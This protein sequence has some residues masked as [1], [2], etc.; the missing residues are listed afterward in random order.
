MSREHV[1]AM[2]PCCLSEGDRLGNL[3]DFSRGMNNS[4]AARVK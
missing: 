2:I 3:G 4:S 1:P